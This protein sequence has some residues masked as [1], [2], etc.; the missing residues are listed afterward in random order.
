MGLVFQTGGQSN[1][2]G[3]QL[4][5]SYAIFKKRSNADR[6]MSRQQFKFIVGRKLPALTYET[7]L[8][9]QAIS[10]YFNIQEKKLKQ[11]HKQK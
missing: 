2:Q 4:L 10:F 11:K 7:C 9:F 1:E 8:N 6:T 5:P 3:K